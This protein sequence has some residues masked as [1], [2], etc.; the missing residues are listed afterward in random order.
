MKK[1]ISLMLALAMIFSMSTISASATAVNTTEVS[2]I[3]SALNAV[4][5]VKEQ[6]GL[7]SVDFEHLSYST[8]YIYAYDYTSEGLV[9]NS[10]FIPIAYDNSLIGWII[11][12]TN[13]GNTVYQFSTAFVD[14]V[15]SIV[16]SEMSIAFIYDCNASYMYDGNQ[17]YK[18]GD[19]SLQVESRSILSTSDVL[20]TVNVTLNR[21]YGYNDLPYT[22]INTNSRAPIYYSC[23]V[24]FV[25]QNPPSNLC[26]AASS[27]CIINYLNDS[28]TTADSVARNWFKTMVYSEYN[29]TLPFS[30]VDDVLSD[31]GISYTGRTQ[32]PSDSIILRNIRNGYPIYGSFSWSNGSHGVVIYGINL[33]SSYIYIMDPE[34]G[35]CTASSS[36]SGAHTF[37]SGYS[38]VTLTLAR[39]VC[40][41]WTT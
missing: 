25:S 22:S 19:I 4:E 14:Q 35:F 15:N 26:W 33:T 17:L 21:L 38:G 29:L 36:A 30:S 40:K 37:V 24:S 11:K 5:C 27:A 8:N 18:L 28:M 12:A 16:S 13:D 1:I 7:A 32:V 39:A 10:E 20:N 31:Y 23:N 3:V 2:E 9:Y 41:Y 34:Y 6:F